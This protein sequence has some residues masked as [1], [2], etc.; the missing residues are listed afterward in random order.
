[1]EQWT[2]HVG[3]LTSRLVV[4]VARTLSVSKRPQCLFIAFRQAQGS[5]V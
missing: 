1:V 5:I 4:M 2:W 3:L